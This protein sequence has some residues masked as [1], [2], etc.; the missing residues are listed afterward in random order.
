[1]SILDFGNDRGL[2]KFLSKYADNLS[3]RKQVTSLILLVKLVVGL[4]TLGISYVFAK[5]LAEI[6]YARA[7]LAYLLPLIGLAVMSYLLFSLTTSYMQAKERFVWWGSLY[8]GSNFVRLI[9][10]T[11]LFASGH[12][13]PVT[14]IIIFALAPLLGF[15][16]TFNQI[17]LG[18]LHPGQQNLAIAKDIYGFNK[19]VTGFTVVS[20]ISSRLDTYV[21]ARFLSLPSVGIYGLANQ[22][23]V[24]LLQL[25]TA[26][27]AVT[28]PKLARFGTHEATRKYVLKGTIFS[29]GIA[30]LA[31]VVMIPAGWIFFFL[32]GQQ[33]LS[34]FWPFLILLFSMLLFL[35]TAPI[36]DSILFYFNRPQFFFW[37][38]IVHGIITVLS[39]IYLIPRYHLL[40]SSLSNLAGQ[41]FLALC[42]IYLY[43]KLSHK[44]QS[45]V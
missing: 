15:I 26:I 29:A 23:V 39:G 44:S 36:R 32:S 2:V 42:A 41:I 33:Y 24:F 11:L 28:A 22:A 19:W 31:A 37:A 10:A 43:L 45:Q 12:L 13:S 21:T 7:N 14:G 18:T 35:V 40:G 8:V 27:G 9:L 16:L 34:G 5:P 38:G 6:F 1:M 20:S 30:F 4:A 17:E 25:V 3:A